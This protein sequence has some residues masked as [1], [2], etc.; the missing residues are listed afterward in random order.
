MQVIEIKGP[1]RG[2]SEPYVPDDGQRPHPGKKTRVL[3]TTNFV[4]PKNKV[5]EAVKNDLA[6]GLRKGR[7]TGGNTPYESPFLLV[8]GNVQIVGLGENH[9]AF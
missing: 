1:I 6:L 8:Q 2:R 7:C 4:T 3:T 5:P 9:A